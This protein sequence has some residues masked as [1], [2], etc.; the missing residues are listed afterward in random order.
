MGWDAFIRVRAAIEARTN[1]GLPS[2]MSTEG[3]SPELLRLTSV[4]A[5]QVSK[6]APPSLMVPVNT[7]TTYRMGSLALARSVS[8]MD[9]GTSGPQIHV[10]RCVTVLATSLTAPLHRGTIA[11]VTIRMSQVVE[12]SPASSTQLATSALSRSIP[13]TT[14]LLAQ[15][16]VPDRASA[17]DGH[18]LTSLPKRHAVTCSWVH[19]TDRRINVNG[20]RSTTSAI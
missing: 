7:V 15:S 11:G 2:S 19:S 8:T 4:K 10:P 20:I 9:V 13:I 1:S 6:I 3:S 18:V 16:N 12:V 14:V 5:L 17:P